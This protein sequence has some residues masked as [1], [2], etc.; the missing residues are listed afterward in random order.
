MCVPLNSMEESVSLWSGGRE[1]TN[2]LRKILEDGYDTCKADN[3][4][5]FPFYDTEVPYSVTG[6]LFH[7]ED[8]DIRFQVKANSQKPLPRLSGDVNRLLKA[9]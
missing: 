2:S 1:L 5:F 4:V 9:C 8:I 7:E 3:I 6:T